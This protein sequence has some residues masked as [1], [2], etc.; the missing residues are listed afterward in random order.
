MME[1][2]K[3]NWPMIFAVIA[4]LIALIAFVLFVGWLTYPYTKPYVK[5]A[6]KSTLHFFGVSNDNPQTSPKSQKSHN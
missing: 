3:W 6:I 4:Y 5:P 1:Q 2:S